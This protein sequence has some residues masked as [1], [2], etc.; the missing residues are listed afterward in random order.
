MYLLLIFLKL[1]M[2]F[3]ANFHPENCMEMKN[4]S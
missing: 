3:I 1:K 4:L 2:I